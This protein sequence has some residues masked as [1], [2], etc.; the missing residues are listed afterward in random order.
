MRRARAWTF[1]ICCV[2]ACDFLCDGVPRDAMQLNSLEFALE[3]WDSRPAVF[4]NGAVSQQYYANTIRRNYSE[5]GLPLAF[6]NHCW[7]VCASDR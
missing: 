3:V 6:F 1:V 5:S 2:T 4:R 7:K